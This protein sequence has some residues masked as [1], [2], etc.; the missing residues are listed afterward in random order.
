[1]QMDAWS[2]PTSVK[3]GLLGCPIGFDQWVS[4]ETDE[5][6][7]PWDNT[8]LGWA[9]VISKEWGKKRGRKS[10]PTAGFPVSEAAMGGR[11]KR[12]LNDPV[13]ICVKYPTAKRRS[14]CQE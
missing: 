1:M 7:A 9:G 13:T 4:A 10:S 2:W 14:C 3:T 12:A 11:E 8:W 5:L 6:D